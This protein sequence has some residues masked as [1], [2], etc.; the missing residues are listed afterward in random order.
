MQ[1]EVRFTYLGVS[2]HQNADSDSALE[3]VFG[4]IERQTVREINRRP[5]GVEMVERDPRVRTHAVQARQHVNRPSKDTL[6][7]LFDTYTGTIRYLK[8]ETPR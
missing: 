5:V 1:N 7:T 8:G 3:T 6:V 4:T 2:D